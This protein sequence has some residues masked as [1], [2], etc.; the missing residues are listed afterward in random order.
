MERPKLGGLLFIAIV[1]VLSLAPV[2]GDTDQ[3]DVSA[4]TNLYTSLRSPSQFTSQLTGWTS[5]GT[6][7]C[8][9]AWKGVYYS[10][11]AVKEIKLYGLGLIGSLGYQ[12]SSLSSLTTLNVSHNSLSGQ[13]S[14]VFGKLLNLSTFTEMVQRKMILILHKQRKI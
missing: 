12:L 10:G 6:D 14:D 1:L 8:G 13:I 11:S 4:L 9:Q 2:D 7:P 5:S 3:R